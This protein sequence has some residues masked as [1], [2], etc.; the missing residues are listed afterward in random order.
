MLGIPLT[1]FRE[2][3]VTVSAIHA[4]KPFRAIRQ[5]EAKI[6][7]FLACIKAEY[8]DDFD[9]AEHYRQLPLRMLQGFTFDE[10]VKLYYSSTINMDR[11]VREMFEPPDRGKGDP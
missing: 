3:L 7:P 8:R 6:E 1:A 9:F 4:Q 10:L 2:Q 5:P 11:S